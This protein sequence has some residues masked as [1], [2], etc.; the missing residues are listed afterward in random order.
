MPIIRC[1]TDKSAY[2]NCSNC[3]VTKCFT[4]FLLKCFSLSKLIT[5]LADDGGGIYFIRALHEINGK[6]ID[7][8]APVTGI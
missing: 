6:T 4:P 3:T 7:E 8:T 1:P 5:L 2:S